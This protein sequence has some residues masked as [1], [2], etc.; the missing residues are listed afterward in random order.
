MDGSNSD[1]EFGG[2]DYDDYDDDFGGGLN[3]DPD[4]LVFRLTPKNVLVSALTEVLPPAIATELVEQLLEQLYACAKKQI[5]SGT[6]GMVFDE[7]QWQF[8]GMSKEGHDEEHN[9]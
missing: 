2:P 8:A 1:S 3:R 4:E 9:E 5:G 6:V 7:G